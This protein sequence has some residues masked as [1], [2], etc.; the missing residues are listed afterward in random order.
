MVAG[1]EKETFSKIFVSQKK[2]IN[3]QINFA[4]IIFS[5]LKVSGFL[6]E[7]VCYLVGYVVA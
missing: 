3:N 5:E 4:I 1:V 6:L 7:V 2:L